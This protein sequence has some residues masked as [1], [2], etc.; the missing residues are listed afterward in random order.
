MVF[1]IPSKTG[2]TSLEC[3]FMYLANREDRGIDTFERIANI[4]GHSAAV[5]DIHK[6][7]TKVILVRNPYE[8]LA[9]ISAS[10]PNSLNFINNFKVL[11]ESIKD[12]V[13]NHENDKIPENIISEEIIKELEKEKEKYKDILEKINQ[14]Q[15]V[16]F[17]RTLGEIYDISKPNY[18]IRIEY[19]IKDL[20]KLNIHINKDKF[21]HYNKTKNKASLSLKNI[22]NTQ[23]KIDFANEY[24]DCAKDA[25]RFGYKP[26]LTLKDL[27]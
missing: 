22:F 10:Y 2:S 27:E 25:V 24:F 7:L 1:I 20:E 5:P 6:N 8:R 16:I 17:N 11:R 3:Y 18:I 23:E 4:F 9:S 13:Y 21:P 15:N 26:I 19:I 14:K 12:K